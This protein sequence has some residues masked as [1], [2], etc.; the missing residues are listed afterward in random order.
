MYI[1]VV[2]M[3]TGGLDPKYHPVLSIGTVLMDDRLRIVREWETL[4]RPFKGCVIDP[5][6]LDVNQLEPEV[7][8]QMGM[9]EEDVLDHIEWELHEFERQ[10]KEPDRKIKTVW[11]GQN[12][13]F[14]WDFYM[15]MLGRNKKMK[16]GLWDFHKLDTWCLGVQALYDPTKGVEDAVRNSGLSKLGNHYGITFQAHNALA[17]A[18]ASAELIQKLLLRD[19][20]LESKREKDRTNGQEIIK[21]H[22][23]AYDGDH[24][25]II[26]AGGRRVARHG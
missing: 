21:R 8:A 4:V 18:K 9:A 16:S 14:D 25:T 22:R 12:P 2:D 19:W 6:A 3:E 26:D 5:K 13:S 17:D 15:A 24:E 23:R 20:L 7:C 10:A 11:A 1:L